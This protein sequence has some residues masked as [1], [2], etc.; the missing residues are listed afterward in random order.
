M[1]PTNNLA[2]RPIAAVVEGDGRKA[3]LPHPFFQNSIFL[4]TRARNPDEYRKRSVTVEVTNRNGDIMTVRSARTLFAS[5][6]MGVF[7]AVVAL[8]QKHGVHDLVDSVTGEVAGRVRSTFPI[9]ELYDLTGMGRSAARERLLTSL[10]VLGSVS[11]SV[12]YGLTPEN[13]ERHRLSLGFQMSSFWDLN[14]VPRKGRRGS[15]VELFPSRYLIP[16]DH[17]LW[18]DAALCNALQIDTARAIFWAL[19]CRQHFCGT[20]AEW[21]KLLG[22]QY[23]ALRNWRANH[24]LPALEELTKYGYKVTEKSGLYTVRR[25]ERLALGTPINV[26]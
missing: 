14:I 24:F 9:G 3:Y 15:I 4:C 18:A 23:Q 26:P 1:E 12:K 8:L 11:L 2:T 7:L 5:P 16:N 19:I 25:P 20:V 6:D 10:D 22:S 21:Q 13:L 17:N